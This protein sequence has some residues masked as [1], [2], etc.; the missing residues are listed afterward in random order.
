MIIEKLRQEVYDKFGECMNIKDY[1][2]AGEIIRDN[3]HLLMGGLG[4]QQLL[5]LNNGLLKLI[6]EATDFS[7][8]LIK[9]KE[10]YHLELEVTKII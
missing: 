4:S 5:E 8:P 6:D 2:G 7:T 1:V 3:P 10:T 9:P